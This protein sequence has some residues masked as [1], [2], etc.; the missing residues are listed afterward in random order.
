[1][2][3]QNRREARFQRASCPPA[4]QQGQARPRSALLRLAERHGQTRQPTDAT[5]CWFGVFAPTAVAGAAASKPS[6]QASTHARSHSRTH[7]AATDRMSACS[8]LQVLTLAYRFFPIS[9]WSCKE[10]VLIEPCYQARYVL[11]RSHDHIFGKSHHFRV[12]LY[13][14]K[15]RLNLASLH[16]MI[17]VGL[18]VLDIKF[19]CTVSILFYCTAQYFRTTVGSSHSR[20]RSPIPNRIKPP[21]A[22]DRGLGFSGYVVNVWTPPSSHLTA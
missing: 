6:K 22:S 1:M 4:C 13:Q 5:Q 14:Q 3:S 11:Y 7:Q 17:V 21:P 9:L 16:R 10:H 8:L 19:Y 15:H 12:L 2:A 18:H 20:R